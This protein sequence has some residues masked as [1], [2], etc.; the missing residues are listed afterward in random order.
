MQRAE[1]Y[2]GKESPERSEP[3]G[4][5]EVLFSLPKAHYA[6][7]DEIRKQQTSRTQRDRARQVA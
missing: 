3:D 2:F 7:R 1:L 5:E 4:T 6:P